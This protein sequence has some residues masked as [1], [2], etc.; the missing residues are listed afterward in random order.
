MST[1][2]HAPGP[3]RPKKVVDP[4]FLADALS[5][6]RNITKSQLAKS[7]G[8][9]RKTLDKS[10]QY[11][12]IE[13]GYSSI[14]SD[15]LDCILKDY[16]AERPSSGLRFVTA[17]LRNSDIKLQR[18][19]IRE[20]LARVD[21]LATALR[22]NNTIQRRAYVSSGPG[23]LWHGDGHHKLIRWGFVIHGFIDG[24]DRMV[25]LLLRIL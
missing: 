21:G 25:S 2:H 13:T 11:A 19:R 15:E 24:Y 20:S 1:I 3:G 22:K 16:K 5:P 8:I 23:K 14:T 18:H 12:N 6:Q 9:D 7:L 10:I 17:H 4:H